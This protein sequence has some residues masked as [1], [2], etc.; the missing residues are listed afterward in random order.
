MTQ[1]DILADLEEASRIAKSGEDM[2]LLGSSIGLMWGILITFVFTYQYLILSG[3]IGL[4]EMTL[5][6]AW[7]SFGIIGGIGSTILGRAADRK[8]GANSVN[9]RV[10]SYVWIM[11]AGSMGA[12]TVGVFLNMLFGDGNQTVWNTV[13]ILSLIHI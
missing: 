6:F 1:K 3:R 13:L 5:V 8:P 10:E 4:P 12:L 9:N 2:P 7:I 11:F